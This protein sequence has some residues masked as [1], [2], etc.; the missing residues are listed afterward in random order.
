MAGTRLTEDRRT[1]R[2]ANN[3]FRLVQAAALAAFPAVFA[4]ALWAQDPPAP[5]T[6]D[7]QGG[8]ILTRGAI[9]EAFASAIVHDP[10]PGPIV[11]KTP[12]DPIQELPPDQRPEGK[13]IQWIPGYWSYDT[14][15]TD[16]VW[17]SGVWREPPPGCQWVPGYWTQVEGGSRWISGTWVP[18][19]ADESSG[20]AYLSQPPASLEAGP[21]SPQPGPGVVWTPGYWQ[22][23]GTAY[24]WRPGFWAAVQ[25]S[26]VWIPAHYVCTPGGW[27][28]VAGYW[29]LPLTNRGLM[30]S[31]VYY[32]QPVYMR[33]DFVMTPSVAIVGTA[34]TSNLFVQVGSGQYLYGDYY[35]Q[36][37]VG[38]GVTPWFSFAFATG[39]PV[40]YD[41]VFSYY[42]VVA[43]RQNP[44]WMVQVREQYTL[45]RDNPALRPPRTLAEQSRLIERETR[46]RGFSNHAAVAMRLDHLAAESESG[47]GMRMVRVAQAERQRIIQ[48]SAELHTFRE[49]RLRA[50]ERGAA[51]L[52][53]GG[54]E[55]V[56]PRP[57]ALPRS[58]I[59]ARPHAAVARNDGQAREGERT[60]SHEQAMPP[61]ERPAL[62]SRPNP[63]ESLRRE[64]AGA[65]RSA[66]APFE[67][68]PYEPSRPMGRYNPRQPAPRSPRPGMPEPERRREP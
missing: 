48:Q 42:S 61:H 32:P 3:R 30:F 31:P 57:M 18:S 50:E 66:R 62:E 51:A 67:R 52:R 22:W 56:R 68:T 16:F 47:R 36:S 27:I 40:F 45:R 38:M 28:F 23:Q 6:A 12:P 46:E 59:A 34:V 17:T 13:N 49:Q 11:P 8:E 37:F 65:A 29:D 60:V 55:A 63:Q 35:G 21:S 14:T 24:A 41:P 39:P 15:R 26:W 64:P 44:Q 5:P 2:H 20:P 25:P 4:P 19:Q 43:V 7:A 58:P 33:A 9:H 1:M 53:A 10:K 54:R